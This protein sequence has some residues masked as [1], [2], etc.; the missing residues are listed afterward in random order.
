[1]KAVA[2]MLGLAYSNAYEQETNQISIGKK[3]P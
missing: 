3:V 1:M 2:L